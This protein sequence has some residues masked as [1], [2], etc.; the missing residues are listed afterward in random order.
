MSNWFLGTNFYSY[1][2][3]TPESTHMTS[4]EH[5]MKYLLGLKENV[6]ISVNSV[7]NVPGCNA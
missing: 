2:T 7:L 6:L 5:A 3:L 1:V 4:E